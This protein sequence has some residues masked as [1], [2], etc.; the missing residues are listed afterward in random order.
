MKPS[1]LAA[2]QSVSE[3]AAR[4]LDAQ[5]LLDACDEALTKALHEAK[6]RGATV[7]ELSR[8][9]GLARPTIYQRLY[10]R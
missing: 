4:R 3:I 8:L 5:R 6:K 9:S 2:R 7:T 1:E 10:G